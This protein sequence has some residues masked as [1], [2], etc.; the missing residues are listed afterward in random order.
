M[1]FETRRDS[2]FMNMRSS[3]HRL[4]KVYCSIVAVHGLDGHRERT[5]TF[6][7]GSH[8]VLWLRDLLPAEI[9]NARIWT[10]GY[11][12]RTHSRSHQDHLTIKTLYDHGRQLVIDLDIERRASNSHQRPII[13]VAH[14]LG[15]IVVKSM[16]RYFL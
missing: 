16:S 4:T 2:S 8:N 10:W 7:S 14:S 1:L 6:E 11:D 3:L 13:F 5:W 9:P 12:S 15:G